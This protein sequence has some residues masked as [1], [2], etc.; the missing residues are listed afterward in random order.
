MFECYR[1]QTLALSG[2]KV[3]ALD[4]LSWVCWIVR[5]AQLDA[6]SSAITGLT[7]Q[8]AQLWASRAN[9]SMLDNAKFAVM[10]SRQQSNISLELTDKVSHLHTQ[11]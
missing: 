4:A 7:A 9:T 11:L 1:I 6:R 2:M 10:Q 5:P 3:F 8:H